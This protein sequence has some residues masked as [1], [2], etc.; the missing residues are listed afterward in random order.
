MRKRIVSLLMALVMVFSLIPTTVFAAEHDNQVR[1][2]VE[3]TTFHKADGAAWEGTLV[4]R[5]VNLGSDS[6]IM[7]CIV[8]ALGT[9]S[10]TGAESGFITEING[11]KKRSGG[12]RMVRLD[13]YA[14]RLVHQRRL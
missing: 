3:N 11:L 13:G 2:I 1:V 10:Q 12:R 4:D 6:T 14:E 9:Y 7:S 5:W 8:D